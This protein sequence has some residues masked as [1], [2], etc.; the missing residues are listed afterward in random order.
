MQ[1]TGKLK[2]PYKL[3]KQ[4]QA[5]VV[6]GLTGTAP[7]IKINF[8]SC[9]SIVIYFQEV[10][11]I[12]C[13]LS[14]LLFP[15]IILCRPNPCRHGGTCSIINS[16]QFSCDCEHTGYKGSLCEIG[17][18]SPPDFPKLISGNPSQ[19]LEL[20]AKPDNSLTVHFNPTMNLTIQPKEVTIQHPESKAVFQVTGNKSGVGMVS[21]DLEGVN[22]YDFT[23]PDNSFV[24]VGRNISSQKSIYTRLGLLVGELPIGCQQEEINNYPECNIKIAFDSNTTLSSGIVIES[25]PVHIVT[26]DHKKIPLSL[27]GYNSSSPHPSPKEI[28]ERVVR[29][30]GDQKSSVHGCSDIQLT[31][32]LIEFIQKDAF[33][34]S[35][36]RYFTNQLPLW[37]K[38][39][40]TEE[41]NLFDIHNTLAS[42]AQTRE[43]QNFHPI[44][45]FPISNQSV[46]VLYRPTLNFNIFIENE[47]L[48]LSSK[49]SCFVT[50]ICETGVFLSL[51]QKAS[52]KVSRMLVMQDLAGG[53]WELL[54]SAFGFTT[55]R[56][57][58]TNLV[59]VPDGHLA[60][61]FSDFRYN[62][63][64]HGSANI[65]LRNSSNQM[66]AVNIKMTGEAF[67]FADDL[68]AVSI[69][70]SF[71]LTAVSI[72][73]SS[74]L[75]RVEAIWQSG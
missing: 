32:G 42:L 48:S 10:L 73:F 31:A 8:M 61:D 46:V 38:I 53:G 44:C 23:T 55:P 11:N 54:V 14:L 40:V 30:M 13:F 17:V 2:P 27:V 24:F 20:Q 74:E 66:F 60:E 18:V 69:T 7:N 29:D 71:S 68:N 43:A 19:I 57:Y 36:F 12:F 50:H 37:L 28:M 62:L 59:G 34:K 22:K 3:S 33:P 58:S 45:K 4:H 64:L 1:R 16:R 41:S 56:R 63:W 39:T 49:G 65:L 51:P 15:E 5:L 70:F 9:N 21:Y 26:P 6:N 75:K 52:N 72:T 67:A 35:F 25:G 47:Q